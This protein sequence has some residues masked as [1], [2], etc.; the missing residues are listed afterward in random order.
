MAA[1]LLLDA[2]VRQT[3]R[4]HVT[5]PMG[6][7][8]AIIMQIDKTAMAQTADERASD[9]ERR[10]ERARLHAAMASAR[11]EQDAA[12]GNADSHSLHTREA[13]LHA[14]AANHHAEAAALQRLH[15]AHLRGVRE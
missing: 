12:A 3:Y 6:P 8:T 9:A 5:E 11:A 2:G 7:G 14:R 15:A 1:N 13:A 4:V 10:A